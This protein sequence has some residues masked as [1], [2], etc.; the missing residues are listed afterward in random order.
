MFL[1]VGGDRVVAVW[2]L[3]A[4]VDAHIFPG[5]TEPEFLIKAR[6]E[7]CYFPEDEGEPKAYVVAED[8][9]YATVVTAH[10]LR[11]RA[12]QLAAFLDQ[13]ATYPRDDK[14]PKFR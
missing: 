6:S 11:R 13:G 4:V 12:E 14:P 7:G 10:T 3:I 8:G 2:D 1:H 5:L 9:V